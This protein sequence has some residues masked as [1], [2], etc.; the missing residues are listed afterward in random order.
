[1]PRNF[2]LAD[3]GDFVPHIPITPAMANPSTSFRRSIYIWVGNDVV[4]LIE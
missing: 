4:K 2:G 1:M 3:I